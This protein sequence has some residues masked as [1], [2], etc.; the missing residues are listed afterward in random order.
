MATTGELHRLIFVT[1]IF[2]TVLLF[3]FF[4]V[5]HTYRI[6]FF[7]GGG[8]GNCNDSLEWHTCE[9]VQL[10]FSEISYTRPQAIVIRSWRLQQGP[11]LCLKGT[12]VRTPNPHLDMSPR[13]KLV[14]SR[15]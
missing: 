13:T 3:A 4:S 12:P 7:W 14:S 11:F 10:S 15:H 9:W 1:E 6:G 5:L 8:G 2:G